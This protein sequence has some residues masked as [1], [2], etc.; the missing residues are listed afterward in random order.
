MIFISIELP[1]LM[2]NP[3]VVQI[4]QKYKKTPA[5]VLLRHM[6]EKDIAVIPKSVNPERI[7]QNIDVSVI[8]NSML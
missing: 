5:Q 6:I 1:N 4:A 2:E 3:V 8:I 7:K